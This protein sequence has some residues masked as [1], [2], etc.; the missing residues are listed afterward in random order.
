S[1]DLDSHAHLL[2]TPRMDCEPLEIE[3]DLHV[4]LGELDSQRFVT[5]DVRRAVIV[6]L[7]GNVAVG[8]QLRVFLSAAF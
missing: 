2:T 6:T 7:D 4:M 5:M 1:D 3:K 8:V